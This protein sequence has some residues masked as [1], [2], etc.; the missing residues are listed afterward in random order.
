MT[1]RSSPHGALWNPDSLHQSLQVLL[2]E[3]RRRLQA[4]RLGMLGFL[5]THLGALPRPRQPESH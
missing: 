3:P 1:T 5:W 4:S 2:G